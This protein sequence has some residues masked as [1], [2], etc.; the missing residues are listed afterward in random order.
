MLASAAEKRIQ[1]RKNVLVSA[2]LERRNRELQKTESA[3][4]KPYCHTLWFHIHL[5]SWRD[6]TKT[7]I[8]RARPMLTIT[9]RLLMMTKPLGVT[10]HPPD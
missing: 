1:A 10:W 5:R 2:E 9:W 3:Q 7:T 4:F 6:S 8:G